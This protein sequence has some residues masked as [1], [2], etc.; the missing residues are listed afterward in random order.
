MSALLTAL[1]LN[2]VD[3]E[4]LLPDVWIAAHPEH[5]L[6]YRRDEAE[7]AAIA[8]R[9]GAAAPADR[10]P[11]TLRPRASDGSRWK[12]FGGLPSRTEVLLR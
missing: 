8:G 6:T 2:E 1:S 3:L 5:F 9:R 10:A 4:A 7:A 12:G 11:S